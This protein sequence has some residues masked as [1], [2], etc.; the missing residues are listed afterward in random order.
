MKNSGF[1]KWAVLTAAFLIGAISSQ[2]ND[3][4]DV[5]NKEELKKIYTLKSYYAEGNIEMAGLSGKA[6]IYFEFPDRY[7]MNV[8]LSVLNITQIYNGQKAWMIDQNGQLVE[9]TGQ[10]KANLVNSVYL[11]GYSFLRDDG[12][13]GSVA[14]QSDSLIKDSTYK[15]FS[16]LPEGGDSLWLYYNTV[17]G[18][19]DIIREYLDEI[20]VMTY[21][22]DFRD[23]GGIEFSFKSKMVSSLPTLN[24][25]ITFTSVKLNVNIPDTMFFL[26]PET[27]VDY[28]F[29]EN[30]DSVVIPFTFYQ[31]HIYLKARINGDSTRYFIL[32][33]GA[34]LNILNKSYADAIGLSYEGGFAAKGV[35]GYGEASIG[36]LDSMNLDG[37]ALYNQSIAVTDMDKMMTDFEGN[38]LG[39]IIGYDVL[40][41]FP[42][43]IDY[44]GKHLVF[45]NPSTFTPPEDYHTGDFE[46]F[47]KIP[48]IKLDFEGVQAVFLIDLGNAYS[49]ILH[50]SFIAKHHLR[51]KLI[52]LRKTDYAIG[53]VGGVTA[54]STAKVAEFDFGGVKIKDQEVWIADSETGVIGSNEIDGNIGN[55]LLEKFS[56]ILDYQSKKLYI[57][58]LF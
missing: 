58:S 24:S 36:R 21:S 14:Y 34:G 57:K 19:I 16:A 50:N 45:Y 41:R 27:F 22:S 25:S 42:I 51:D 29:P 12:M 56:I 28:E 15:I 37:I 38:S 33:S 47:L 8:S 6:E 11:A 31:G 1:I 43:R 53:G 23:V 18:R 10:D 54:V 17:S 20:K 30:R 44:E 4:A 40:S 7:R 32:D 35:A 48:S 5:Y 52:D 55:L 39:G 2:A 46:L 26:S 9:Q 3:L 13:K 49:I